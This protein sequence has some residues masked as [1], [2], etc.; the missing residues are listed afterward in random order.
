M[1]DHK[2]L[3]LKS[4]GSVHE[5]AVVKVIDAGAFR[6]KPRLHF[7]FIISPKKRSGSGAVHRRKR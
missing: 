3:W 6:L 5:H 2:P 7:N 1:V 4:N